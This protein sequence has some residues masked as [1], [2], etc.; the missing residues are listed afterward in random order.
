MADGLLVKNVSL[1]DRGDYLCRAFQASSVASNVAE[2][3]IKLKVH[4]EFVFCS[5]Y[6]WWSFRSREEKKKVVTN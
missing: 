2:Q 1:A 5:F 3:N 6:I 4:R